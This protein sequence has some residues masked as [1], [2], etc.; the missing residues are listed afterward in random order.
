MQDRVEDQHQRYWCGPTT[1]QMMAWNY[2]NNTKVSQATWASR[3]GTTTSGT[4]IT[5]MVRVANNYADPAR[6]V[7]QQD[8]A[9][10]TKDIGGYTY[11]Q[12]YKLNVNHYSTWRTPVI[13]HPVL[14]KKFFPYLD[15]DGS[16]HFQLGRGW[17]FESAKTDSWQLL[18]YEPWNP[19]Y[20]SPTRPYVDRKQRRWAKNSYLA[21]LDHFQH[22]IGV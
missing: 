21:N 11:A 15:G 14:L 20:F 7:T 19:Q 3:L 13:L 1:M 5:D 22:N 17:D 9:Y 4:V 16:G 8:A 18:Y 2:G 10:V 6:W 12:W